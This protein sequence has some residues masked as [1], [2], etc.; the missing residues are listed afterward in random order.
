MPSTC[1][2]YSLNVRYYQRQ[3]HAQSQKGVEEGG[4][5]REGVFLPRKL[6]SS[7]L[8]FSESHKARFII[9]LQLK[10]SFYGVVVTILA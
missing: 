8:T 9:P 5:A 6:Y 3:T 10:L 4:M 1:G 2:K 7:S